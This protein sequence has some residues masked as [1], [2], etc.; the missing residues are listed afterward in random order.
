LIHKTFPLWSRV[1]GVAAEIVGV[2]VPLGSGREEYRRVVERIRDDDACAGAVVT[3][4]KLALYAAAC[5]MFTTLDMHARDCGEINAIRRDAAGLSGFARDPVSVGRVVDRIWPRRDGD[6]L[7]LGSG[8]TAI[9][10]GRHL[11]AGTWPERAWFADVDPAAG[12]RLRR[13]V[14]RVSVDTVHG[15]GPWDAVVAGLRPG[16]LIVNATGLGKD[17]PGSPVTRAVRFPE[18]AAVWEL[19]YRGDLQLLRAALAQR[20]TRGLNVHDGWS[21][22]CHGWASALTAVFDL[23]DAPAVGD[24]FISVARH[25]GRDA[26]RGFRDDG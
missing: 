9:A 23:T 18:R 11:S 17:R 12:V 22:F 14:G 8:G 24:R 25:L 16:S 21:L 15:D 5:D 10:L 19:N 2:D 20:A 7:C 4:H 6:L 1:L 26:G 3:S 13:A